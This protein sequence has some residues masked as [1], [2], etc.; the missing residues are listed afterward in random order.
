[1]VVEML[2]LLAAYALGSVS[3]AIVVCRLMG[4]PDPRTLGSKNP[5]ATNVLRFGGKQAAA[6][7]LTGDV[8]K[9]LLPVLIAH[10]LGVRPEVLALTGIAAFL[11]HLYPVFF[12]FRGGKG[13]ATLLGVMIGFHWLLGLGSVLIWLV[14]AF[15]FHI[16]SL[17][18]LVMTAVAP[19]IGYWVTG[20][21]SITAV[22]VAMGILLFWRHR[23]N[24]RDLVSGKEEP[25]G[26]DRQ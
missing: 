22:L 17:S 1:M 26:T 12:G 11:G 13:V 3:S 6:L 5:G 24:I 9:G 21:R 15:L 25:I 16:S 8:L 10:G 2:L 14:M 19:V 18:A 4:L 23:S 20:S 7:A